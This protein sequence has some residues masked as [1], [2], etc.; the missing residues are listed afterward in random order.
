MEKE[1]VKQFRK[2]NN[3]TQKELAEIFDVSEDYISKIERG[4]LPVTEN[5][6]KQIKDYKFKQ[7]MDDLEEDPEPAPATMEEVIEEADEKNKKGFSQ[8]LINYGEQYQTQ[9]D[10]IE[11]AKKVQKSIIEMAKR[12]GITKEMVIAYCQTSAL[13]DFNKDVLIAAIKH[14]HP[15]EDCFFEG[16][17]EDEENESV[18]TDE[19]AIEYDEETGEVISD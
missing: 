18:E 17:D 19:N 13:E 1:E 16:E 5:I 3:F 14:S 10:N 4:V 12:E 11:R 15:E 7:E 9:I 8:S 6:E 2:D